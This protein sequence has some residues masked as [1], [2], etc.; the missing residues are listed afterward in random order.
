MNNLYNKEYEM[1]DIKNI[2]MCPECKCPLTEC[3]QCTGCHRQ[4]EYL[5]G[6]YNIVSEKIS[7]DSEYLY[8]VTDEMLADL[9]SEKHNT[10]RA[11]TTLDYYA[12]WNSETLDAQKKQNTYLCKIIDNLSGVVCDLATG[13][14]SML[15]KILNVK[16]K[17]FIIVCTDI[18]ITQLIMTRRHLKTDDKRVF[19]VG[20][21]GRQ[22]S[23]K[24]NSFDYITSLSGF[25]NIPEG[26]RVAKELYR[27][28][29]PNGKLI[30]QGEYIEMGSKSFEL[31]KSVGVER[32]VVEEYLISD[33]R[34][35]GFENIESTI[36]AEAIWAEN[37]YDLIPAAG[38]IKRFCI[39]QAQKP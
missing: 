18:N 20:T 30:L 19:Y 7:G 1:T 25:G 32:G 38:D 22:M 5:H 29:K 21:D 35:A 4:Y 17:N 16:Q 12:K 39:I 36:V 9:F 8:K 28:L 33:L 2:L 10:K 11:E 24:S 26:N 3:L 14:G 23:I 13:G 31:A 6:V 37:P 15:E 34:D 27:I